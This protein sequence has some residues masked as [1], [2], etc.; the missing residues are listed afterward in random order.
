MRY[1]NKPALPYLAF[2]LLLTAA[3]SIYSQTQPT[4][5]ELGKTI[6][7]NIVAGEKQTY[8]LSLASGMYGHV[9][10]HQK[11][12]MLA[13]TVFAPDDKHIRFVDL[14]GAIGLSEEFSLIA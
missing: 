11:T 7:Q 1:A 3:T 2:L 13:V 4:P 9:E 5:L 6:E 14:A 10:V 8:S 12:V